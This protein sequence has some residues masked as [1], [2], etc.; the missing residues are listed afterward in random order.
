VIG[1]MIQEGHVT[2]EM[3]REGQPIL[4]HL[5]ILIRRLVSLPIR[6]AY[7]ENGAEQTGAQTMPSGGYSIWIT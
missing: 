2:D 3:I 4:Q 7:P 5:A 1:E 6:S